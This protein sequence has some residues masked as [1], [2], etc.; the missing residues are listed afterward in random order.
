VT[1]LEGHWK[2]AVVK[3]LEGH[4]KGAVVTCLEGHWKGAVVTCL[5]GHWGHISGHDHSSRPRGDAVGLPRQWPSV[6]IWQ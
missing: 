3:Y 4:W 1:C 5:E 6:D 2:E